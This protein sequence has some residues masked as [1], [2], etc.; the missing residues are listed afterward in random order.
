MINELAYVLLNNLIWG[1]WV[2]FT[3]LIN[4]LGLNATHVANCERQTHGKSYIS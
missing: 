2:K 3:P 1:I 4:N